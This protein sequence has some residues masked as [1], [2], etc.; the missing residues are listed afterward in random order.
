M[1][2]P[3][4]IGAFMMIKKSLID[5]IGPL[6]ERFF[7]YLEETDFCK[8]VSD[9][10]FEVWHLPELTLT[11]YQGVTARKFDLR[12]KI[13]FQRSLYKFFLKHRG[14]IQTTIL[15]VGTVIKL[16]V[17]IMLNL[18][19][20]FLPSAMVRTKRSSSLLIWHVLG[21]PYGWGLEQ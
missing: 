21:M 16:I 12:R 19:L 11:H 5:A 8:R 15:Y 6:D 2:M 4:V 3:S 1:Q 9:H 7:F 18:P 10:G 17:E 20:M 14:K 13:E